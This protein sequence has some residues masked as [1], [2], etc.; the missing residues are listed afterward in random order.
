MRVSCRSALTC[1]DGWQ[2][3]CMASA[4]LLACPPPRAGP[5]E[6]AGAALPCAP[7]E[8]RV[9]LSVWAQLGGIREQEEAGN[10][11]AYLPD[12]RSREGAYLGVCAWGAGLRAHPFIVD[13]QEQ[14]QL[15]EENREL[16]VQVAQLQE[17][18]RSSQFAASS[19][20]EQQPQQ[21]RH[22]HCQPGLFPPIICL[23]A[24]LPESCCA[25]RLAP[26]VLLWH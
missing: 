25:T 17:R 18:L 19:G 9:E 16:K 23:P 4:E 1:I 14:Q 6:Q 8:L 24:D 20:L 10:L 22:C 12:S 3:C 7:V 21:V 15:L 2:P 5:R 13:L 11:E 26:V